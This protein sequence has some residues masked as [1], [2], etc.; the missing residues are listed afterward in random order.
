MLLR[1][2][3]KSAVNGMLVATRFAALAAFGLL[4]APW[5]PAALA[6]DVQSCPE[7]AP[8]AC[9]AARSALVEAEA[10]VRAAAAK[11]AL[12]TTAEEALEVARSAFD[13][14]EYTDAEI[15]ARRAVEQAQL[16]IAQT[17]YPA[18]RLPK[19]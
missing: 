8:P 16:G 1:T 4:A 11:R 19:L 7:R 18:F 6:G 12:W 2:P 14:R 10:A 15:A 17:E 13:R 9:Q 3:G 5:T